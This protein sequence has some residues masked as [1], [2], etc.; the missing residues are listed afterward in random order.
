MLVYCPL[1]GRC[2]HCKS[3]L[4][5]A[6]SVGKRKLC[7]PIP[8][9][10]TIV[11]TDMRCTSCSK[12]F[13]SHDP[14]YV[15]SLPTSEQLKREFVAT[16]G[17]GTDMSLIRLLRSGMTVAQVERFAQSEIW[18]EYLRRKANYVEEWDKVKSCLVW[19][20]GVRGHS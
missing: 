9:P 18:A 10:K 17:N 12:H 4:I 6:N 1:K 14:A 15:Q 8:W 19:C 16:K 11:G 7:Y 3:A 2:P 5:L 20:M 13:M